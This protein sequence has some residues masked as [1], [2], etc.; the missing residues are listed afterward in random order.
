MI[1]FLIRIL[2]GYIMLNAGTYLISI[3]YTVVFRLKDGS[4]GHWVFEWN[5]FENVKE[6]AFQQLLIPIMVLTMFLPAV[7][8][9]NVQRELKDEKEKEKLE[10]EKS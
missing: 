10:F 2:L 5:K 7:L 6:I 1:D 8:L 4:V 3:F 9:H